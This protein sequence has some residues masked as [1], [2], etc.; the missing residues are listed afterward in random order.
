MMGTCC[1]K[2]SA[3]LFAGKACRAG[4]LAVRARWRPTL[5]NNGATQQGWREDWQVND[6]A[7]ELAKDARPHVGGMLEAWLAGGPG[8]I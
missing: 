6:T 5:G 8:H 1:L 3:L 7:D 4:P 2:R